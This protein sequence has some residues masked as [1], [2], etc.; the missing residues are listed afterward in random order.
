[1]R[2]GNRA[3]ATESIR[4]GDGARGDDT[5]ERVLF[6]QGA[7]RAGGGGQGERVDQDLAVDAEQLLAGCSSNVGRFAQDFSGQF[8]I[9]YFLL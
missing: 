4:C 1:M 2:G 7:G 5:V 9:G 3:E 6:V 8:Q